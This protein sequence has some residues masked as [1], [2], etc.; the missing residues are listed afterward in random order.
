MWQSQTLIS[1]RS[2]NTVRW[3]VGSL[4]ELEMALGVS[5]R[6]SRCQGTELDVKSAMT[7]KLFVVNFVIFY[8]PFFYTLLIMPTVEGCPEVKGL[9]EHPL[10]GK[11][12]VGGLQDP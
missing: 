1:P 9:T 6:G 8:Y 10:Q 3:A 2:R 4:L 5:L 7:L 12:A 11:P